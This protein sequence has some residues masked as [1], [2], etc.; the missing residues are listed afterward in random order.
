M[1]AMNK[2][3]AW[4]EADKII[5]NDYMQD[6]ESSERAGYPIYRSV[7]EYYDYICDLG[8]RLEVNLANGKSINIWIE[9]P[10]TIEEYADCEASTITIRTYENGNSRDTIRTAT[11]EEKRI[12][13]P[14]I[15]GALSAIRNG[16]DKQT[17]M[18]V[19]EYIGIHSFG[20]TGNEQCNAYDSIYCKIGKCPNYLLKR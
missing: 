2:Q 1:K 19:A 8:D 16:E 11:E 10:T 14:I 12:L 5:Q 18:S 17:A 7:V 4:S 6:Y 20:Y 15:A 3:Q 9:Q 13:K